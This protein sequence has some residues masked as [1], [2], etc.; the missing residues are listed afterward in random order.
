MFKSQVSNLIQHLDPNT[1]VTGKEVTKECKG[2]AINVIK[3]TA[4]PEII[5]KLFL[6][7]RKMVNQIELS[8]TICKELDVPQPKL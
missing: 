8:E 7:K 3:S 2:V 4:I 1:K 5:K 6:F